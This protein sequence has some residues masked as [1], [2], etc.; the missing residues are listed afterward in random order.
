VS[1]HQH[2]SIIVAAVLGCLLLSGC[3]LIEVRRQQERDTA[4]CRFLGTVTASDPDAGP[5]I[6]LLIRKPAAD[7]GVDEIIDSFTLARAGHFYFGVTEPGTYGIAAFHDLDK[8]L[9]YNL[10]EPAW[11]SD[12]QTTFRVTPGDTVEGIEITIDPAARAPV[13]G[14]IDIRVHQARSRSDQL[15]LTFGQVAVIGDV[16]DLS[17]ERFGASSGKFGFERPIDFVIELGAGIYFLE[18]YDP[19]RVPVLFVHGVNGYPQEFSDLIGAL[20]RTHFQPWFFFYPSGAHL[21]RVSAGLT[22]LLLQLRAMHGFDRMHVVAHSMGG[23]VSRDFILRLYDTTGDSIVRAFVS[24][25]TPWSGHGAA[26]KGVE[27]LP[28]VVYSWIDIAPRSTFLEQL[29]YS[30]TGLQKRRRLLPEPVSFHLLFG[31]RRNRLLPGASGDKVV[32]VASELR[33]EA[34]QEADSVYGFDT[35]HAGILRLPETAEM[36]NAILAG[37]EQ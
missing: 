29:F 10:D 33:P 32:T 3:F 16:V 1:R 37:A 5:L 14:P 4:T 26:A 9:T 22:Q 28:I 34:Q 2:F 6:A 21:D 19:N 20:D 7:G 36:L 24:L 17:N 25:S 8:N 13:D 11:V 15:G 31:F 23:L 27:R 12:P 30:N 35:D 18:E